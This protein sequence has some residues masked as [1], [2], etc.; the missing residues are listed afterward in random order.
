MVLAQYTDA[1]DDNFHAGVHTDKG[2]MITSPCWG[3]VYAKISEA[4]IAKETW[5]HLVYAIDTTQTDESNDRAKLYIDGN[6]LTLNHPPGLFHEPNVAECSFNGP[7]EH[8]LGSWGYDLHSWSYWRGYFAEYNFVDGLQLSPSDF[9]DQSKP[10]MYTGA[11]GPNGFHL[12]FSDP[13]DLGKDIS[14]NG[15]HWV[16]ER[17]A[18]DASEAIPLLEIGHD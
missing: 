3:A 7:A 14:G 9:S 18:S 17:F 10:K 11:Y 8:E 6:L 5:H 15:N 16:P 1:N 2:M 12:D 13:Y 4:D